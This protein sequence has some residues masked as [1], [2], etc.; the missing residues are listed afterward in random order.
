MN[1]RPADH[2]HFAIVIVTLAV[3]LAAG[4]PRSPTNPAHTPQQHTAPLA[5]RETWDAFYIQGDRAGYVQT[6]VSHDSRDGRKILRI[7]GRTRIAIMR[8]GRPTEQEIRFTS[9]E[10]PGGEVIEFDC[11]I[12][13]GSAPLRTS[14]RV[15]GGRMEM[16]TSTKGKTSKNSIPWSAEYGGF[17]AVEHTLL[18]EPMQPGQRRTIRTLQA[19]INEVVVVEMEARDYE[20]VKLLSGTY[21]LLRIDTKMEFP[22][23]QEMQM[24]VW[25]DRTGDT[26]KT[27]TEDMALE[28]FRVTKAEALAE[29][30]PADFDLGWDLLVKV[31]RPLTDAHGTKRVRYRVQLDGGDPAGRFVSGPSQQVKSTGPHTAELTVYALRPGQAEGNTAAG[32]DPPGP[33]DRQ[34]NNIIQS[35]DAGIVALAGKAAGDEQDPWKVAVKLEEYVRRYVTKKDFSQ[36]FATAAEVAENPVGDCSEHAVLLAALARAR[37]IPARVAIGLVYMQGSG[38]FGYHMWS[39]VHVQGRWIPM[40]AT[41]GRGGI[42]AAHLKLAHSNLQGGSALTSFLPVLKVA[43][44]LKIEVEQ[45]E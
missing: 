3:P 25:S 42:G 44:R 33:G 11:E 15:S 28:S 35:D 2:L 1:R 27:L 39:E 40:D 18:R 14:G 7:E 12:R 41:L 43:G 8:F 38:A 32:A 19:A 4:C 6:K 36:A 22:G 45:V 24:I 17:C 21:D 37:G 13:Q 9:I 31:D 34:P 5:E 16:E 29:T 10:T 23:G 30:Q 20:P 26:L